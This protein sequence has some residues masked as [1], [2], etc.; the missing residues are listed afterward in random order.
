LIEQI[1]VFLVIFVAA[2]AQGA[3]GFGFA[4][5]AVPLLGLFMPFKD[6]VMLTLVLFLLTTLIMTIKLNKCINYK[7]AL[8]VI[9][10]SITVS[11]VSIQILNKADND[12]IYRMLGLFLVLMALYLFFIA[13]RLRVRPSLGKALIAGSISGFFGGIFNIEGPPLVVYYLFSGKDKH[14]YNATIQFTFFSAALFRTILNVSNGNITFDIWMSSIAGI[15]GLLAGLKLGV[16]VFRKT[17]TS[18][19]NSIIYI[20]IA[21][22]GILI[23]IRE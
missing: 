2:V 9:I 17:N 23:M 20:F 1:Y 14:E 11:A 5:V 10:A 8:P 18:K 12:L 6:G 21:V 3:I 22:I 7:M 16:Y 19:L 13:K 4:I 15:L